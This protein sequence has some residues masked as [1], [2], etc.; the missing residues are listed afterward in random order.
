MQQMQLL[1]CT[2]KTLLASRGAHEPTLR[3]GEGEGREKS[4]PKPRL[5]SDGRRRGCSMIPP[6]PGAG[7]EGRQAPEPERRVGRPGKGQRMLEL[8]GLLEVWR[9]GGGRIGPPASAS[10]G[11]EPSP[12]RRGCRG[13]AGRRRGGVGMRFLPP[14]RDPLWAT[15]KGLLSVEGGGG[16]RRA[17]SEGGDARALARGS[18]SGRRQEASAGASPRSAPR[19]R[20]DREDAAGGAALG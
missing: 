18:L 7:G 2:P 20:L 13:A 5:A 3:D 11:G 17:A 6:P 15:R 14:P 8:P 12:S 9:G 19:S 10:P 1:R 16:R 4:F